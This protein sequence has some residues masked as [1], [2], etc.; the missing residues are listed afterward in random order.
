LNSFHFANHI[1]TLIPNYFQTFL[2]YS[3]K[4]WIG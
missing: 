1:F 4:E 2:I 3:M